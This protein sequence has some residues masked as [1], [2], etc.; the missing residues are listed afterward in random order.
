MKIQL[1]V[2]ILAMTTNEEL[3]KMTSHCVE[4][5]LENTHDI[6]F[7]IIIVESNKN[8]SESE[9]KYP[10]FVKVIIPD[11]PF[12][13]HKFL[14]I[15]IKQS[16]GEYIA[17]CNND[18][19]FHKNWF[20]EILKVAH[21]HPSIKSFSPNSTNSPLGADKDFEIGHKVQTHVKGWCLIVKS[22]VFPTINY[23]D[24]TFDFYY[25]DN[26]YA[27]SLKTHNIKHAIVYTSY[28]E[29]LEKKSSVLVSESS[30]Q[31]FDYV[32]KYKIP[33]YLL[34]DHFARILQNEKALS[35]FLKF[36][37]K[38]GSPEWVYR[39]DR[40]SKILFKFNLGYFVKFLYQP[41]S[42]SSIYKDS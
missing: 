2:V 6:S 12:N 20:T 4:S 31:K 39:K 8:Y 27:M 15:G 9:F 37:G 16:K 3:Y 28:V 41:K 14:N 5:F 26:D 42:Y 1:S 23:L 18:L 17:L 30:N 35:G 13:F 29:H 33:D 10:D 11:S 36:Y 34:K 32:K 24:D 38:W 19:I 40:I 7:E 25:A 21:K 22:E